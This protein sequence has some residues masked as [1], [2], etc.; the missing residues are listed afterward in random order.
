VLTVDTI[1]PG[2][3]GLTA[4]DL[5]EIV[6]PE[7]EAGVV[8]VLEGVR[9]DGADDAVGRVVPG[10]ES[11]QF[12]S[13]F[14]DNGGQRGAQAETLSR[15]GTYRINPWFARV[16]RI[17]TRELILEWSGDPKPP[18]S[19][20]ASLNQI[21]VNVE[22][23]PLQFDMTQTIRIPAKS[24]PRLVGRFG[25]QETDIFGVSDGL[26]PVPVQRFVERVL[27]REVE[28]YFQSIAS[29]Y[30]VLDFIAHHN[31]VCLEI[32][33]NVRQILDHWEI[34]AV[35]T[36]LTRFESLDL[37][38]DERRRATATERDREQL[39]EHRQRNARVTAAT[40]RIEIGTERERRRAQVAEVEELIRL[41]G[42]DAVAL[43]RY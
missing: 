25:E 38:L 27:G 43:E 20:D 18:S 10:H 11:F 30:N 21:V 29:Q 8:V 41:L 3:H 22:G 6:I 1:G 14:L 42:R 2:R 28:R 15:G 31:E 33:T 19:F 32:E 36:T 40:E 13:I 5:R 7:G 26:N 24:A 9:A 23:Y 17:P 16:V 37:T 12:P 35:R 39:L 34:E 4:A